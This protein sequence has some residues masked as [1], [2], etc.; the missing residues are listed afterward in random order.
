MK[1]EQFETLLLEMRRQQ[2]DQPVT[3]KHDMVDSLSKIGTALCVAGILWVAN[4]IDQQGNK[5]I[6]ISVNQGNIS[7]EIDKFNE[8]TKEPRF[9]RENFVAEMRLYDNR[10]LRVENELKYNAELLKPERSRE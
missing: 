3:V 4:G 9:T 1:D 6:E 10:L 8:F 2:A 5:L 7:S